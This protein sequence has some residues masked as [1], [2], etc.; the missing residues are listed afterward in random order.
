M[1]ERNVTQRYD[2]DYIRQREERVQDAQPV[3]EVAH[4]QDL[5]ATPRAY[6]R[7]ARVR[8]TNLPREGHCL[9]QHQSQTQGG[10]AH[11]VPKPLA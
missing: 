10:G 1:R 7:P 11:F 5:E 6:Q 4:L 9:E 3:D 8:H 2:E